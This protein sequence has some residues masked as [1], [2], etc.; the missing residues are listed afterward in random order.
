[1]SA[2]SSRTGD[3]FFQANLE[4]GYGYLDVRGSLVRQFTDEFDSWNELDE[5]RSTLH[6]TQPT[7]PSAPIEELKISQHIIWAH[8]RANSDRVAIREEAG[9]V[10]ESACALIG[11]TALSRQGLRVQYHYGVEDI[12]QA[13]QMLR[14]RVL[15]PSTG[16]DELGQVATVNLRVDLITDRLKVVVRISP[17][18]RLR[19][20]V[21]QSVGNAPPPEP[22]PDDDFPNTSVLV[23]VD[24]F[25]DSQSQS[26]DPRPFINRANRFSAEYLLPF[27]ATLWEEPQQ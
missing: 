19:A 1:M 24:V 14:P 12:R 2:R 20:Q 17:V 5:N 6:F 11:P 16:W 3:A 10:T 27:I 25:D 9:R 21:I 15:P 7:D 8:F 22:Q 13:V 18:Q 4:D 23:D 26:R